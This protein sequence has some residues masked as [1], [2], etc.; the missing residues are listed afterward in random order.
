MAACVKMV[1]EI[2]LLSAPHGTL[3]PLLKWKGIL[4]LHDALCAFMAKFE[5]DEAFSFLPPEIEKNYGRHLSRKC[6]WQ[7]T[8]AAFRI[9]RG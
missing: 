6:G 5:H 7:R 4:M 1:P 3:H 9:G 8:W 2:I